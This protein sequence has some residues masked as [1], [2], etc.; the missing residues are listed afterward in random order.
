MR[1]FV[2]IEMEKHVRENALSL[3]QLVQVGEAK[4]RWVSAENVHITLKFLGEVPQERL[5]DVQQAVNR[6]AVQSRSFELVVENFGCFPPRGQVRIIWAGVKTS[7]D[8][9]FCLAKCCEEEFERLGFKREERDFSPH[10]TIGRVQYDS[11]RGGLR[12]DVANAALPSVSQRVDSISLYQS[13][14]GPSGA[15]YSVVV[16]E[17]LITDAAPS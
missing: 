17:K 2:A 6:I 15:N 4:I 11:S 5:S 7:G 8:E 16:R 14:L 9:L 10:L 1:L 13:V 12:H 3:R